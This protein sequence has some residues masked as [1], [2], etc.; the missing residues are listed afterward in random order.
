MKNISRVGIICYQ[1]PFFSGG[2]SPDSNVNANKWPQQSTLYCVLSVFN[3][4][5]RFFGLIQV[6]FGL[7]LM[8]EKRTRQQKGE[9]E[10]RVP[11]F[12]CLEAMYQKLLCISSGISRPLC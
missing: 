10:I 7:I 2:V 5:L 8:A 4:V 1:K 12:L 11:F 3:N 6:E 9:S